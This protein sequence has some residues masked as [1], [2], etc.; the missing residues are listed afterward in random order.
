MKQHKGHD[1]AAGSADAARDRAEPDERRHHDERHRDNGIHAEPL[2]VTLDDVAHMFQIGV[3]DDHPA[4]EG[5]ATP[6][7]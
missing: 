3:D 1:P 4:I 6:A 5:D 2:A 7:P